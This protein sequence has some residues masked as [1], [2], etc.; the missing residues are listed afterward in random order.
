MVR[1]GQTRKL[2]NAQAHMAIRKSHGVQGDVSRGQNGPFKH[3]DTAG[4]VWYPKKDTKNEQENRGASEMPAPGK[5]GF[6]AMEPEMQRQIAR[7]GGQ[8]A[9]ERGR[10]HEWTR[11]EAREAS[12][13]GGQAVSRDR[14]HM[15]ELGRKSWGRELEAGDIRYV[16]IARTLEEEVRAGHWCVGD[17]LPPIAKT[18]RRFQAG[19]G[20]VRQAYHVLREA[21]LVAVVPSQGTRVLP[22]PSSSGSVE[23]GQRLASP[24]QSEGGV[25]PTSSPERVTWQEQL[26]TLPTTTH[27]CF[28]HNQRGYWQARWR[29]AGLCQRCSVGKDEPTHP[30]HAGLCGHRSRKP[31][32][33]E[34]PVVFALKKGRPLGYRPSDETRAR[35]RAA[36]LGKPH[37][38]AHLQALREGR[39]RSEQQRGAA[40]LYRKIA[41]ALREQI[42]QGRWRVG[43]RLPSLDEIAAVW[44]VT[45]PTAQ[46]AYRLLAAEGLLELVP[47][48]GTFLRHLPAPAE[49]RTL[50]AS[51]SS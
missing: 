39:E 17:T 10:G 2:V 44:G 45:V 1:A 3:L 14:A 28:S 29:E 49:R 13:Q 7:L 25:R 32:P 47:G 27:V 19:H 21:G 37:S 34:A 20:T 36:L 35:L 15:S 26:A 30:C 51:R 23:G 16:Q 11:A 22:P 12:H 33:I 8:T 31:Q 24:T 18:A 9:H 38:Q 50:G 42:Q 41:Q 4:C 6:A 40:P 46:R 5:R 43:D 48:Q